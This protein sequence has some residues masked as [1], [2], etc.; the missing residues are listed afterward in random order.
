MSLVQSGETNKEYIG[1]TWDKRWIWCS[2]LSLNPQD[3]ED[4]GEG[5]GMKRERSLLLLA[6]LASEALDGVSGM[7]KVIRCLPFLAA[8]THKKS[9]FLCVFVSIAVVDVRLSWLL[10]FFVC[11]RSTK[12][13]ISDRCRLC[14]TCLP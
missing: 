12:H 2:C 5:D 13:Q 1:R 11:N 8:S 14:S 6:G 7:S 3:C 9:M 4:E 10:R